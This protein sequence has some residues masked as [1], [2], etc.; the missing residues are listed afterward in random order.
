M[1]PFRSKKDPEL[2]AF[3]FI[4]HGMVQKYPSYAPGEYYFVKIYEFAGKRF[5][6]DYDR[7]ALIEDKHKLIVDEEKQK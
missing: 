5:F 1:W 2:D 4:N 6:K 7:W 3:I